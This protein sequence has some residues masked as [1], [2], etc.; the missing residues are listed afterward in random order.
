MPPTVQPA[1]LVANAIKDVSRRGQI[2]L[3]A[4]GGSRTT[5]IA[6]E[7]TGRK[8]ILLELDPVYCDVICRR[9]EAYTNKPAIRAESGLPWAEVADLRAEPAPVP[10][11]VALCQEGQASWCDPATPTAPR[12]RRDHPLPQGCRPSPAG[13]WTAPPAKRAPRAITILFIS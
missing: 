13:S 7:K 9:F 1:T 11:Q 8:A 2:V 12:P 6:A 10:R 5:L 4:F 3:D